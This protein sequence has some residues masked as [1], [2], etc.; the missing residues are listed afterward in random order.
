M[1]NTP[2][3]P[4]PDAAMAH[5]ALLLLSEQVTPLAQNASK[6]RVAFDARPLADGFRIVFAWPTF[7]RALDG[8][9]FFKRANAL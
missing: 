5:D 4:D 1:H 6:Y 8:L 9:A 7:P 3:I 2:R